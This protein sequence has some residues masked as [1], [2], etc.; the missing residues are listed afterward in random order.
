[1]KL[2]NPYLAEDKIEEKELKD[3]KEKVW[4][5]EELEEAKRRN[6]KVSDELQAIKK[7]LAKDPKR[8]TK[9]GKVKVDLGLL[10]K[11][12]QKAVIVPNSK[13]R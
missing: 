10:G 8:R 4:T 9:D 2:I 13:V 3:T 1:M 7:N 5:Q 6:K 11:I 12:L